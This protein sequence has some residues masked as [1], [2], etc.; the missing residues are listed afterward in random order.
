MRKRNRRLVICMSEAEW[1]AFEE[2]V[3]QS[4]MNRSVFCRQ[5]LQ[6]M[7]VRAAS[8]HLPELVHQLRNI[9]AGLDALKQEAQTQHL[10]ELVRQLDEALTRN[11]DAE[12]QVMRALV[13][14]RPT[15]R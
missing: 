5:A 4:G 14:E 9:A 6:G 11:R 8:P 3:R 1:T 2:K 7:E 15:W 10:S 13:P 12:K